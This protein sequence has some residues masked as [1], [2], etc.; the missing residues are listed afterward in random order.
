MFESLPLALAVNRRD[1]VESWDM[2]LEYSP[3]PGFLAAAILLLQTCSFLCAVFG[4]RTLS[5]VAVERGARSDGV[6][7]CVIETDLLVLCD[8]EGEAPL[9]T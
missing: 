9:Q 2:P 7:V 1:G 5:P 4:T 3:A 8:E 6:C